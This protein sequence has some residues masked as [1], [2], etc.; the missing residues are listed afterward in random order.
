MGVYKD[1]EIVGKMMG[2]LLGEGELNELR[3]PDVTSLRDALKQLYEVIKTMRHSKTT[4]E[5]D[6]EDFSD[7]LPDFVNG[8]EYLESAL[9]K[10]EPIV[11]RLE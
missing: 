10:I 2:G 11:E 7:I 9:N 1:R 6:Q 8:V 3:E 4:L 5:N